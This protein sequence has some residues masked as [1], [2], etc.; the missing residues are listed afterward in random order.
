VG[1]RRKEIEAYERKNM[2]Q[3]AVENQAM[4]NYVS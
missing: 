1:F 3:G 2:L 4:G